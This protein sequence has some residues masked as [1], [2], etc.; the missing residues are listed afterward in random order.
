MYTSMGLMG[1]LANNRC[2]YM[3]SWFFTAIQRK[4]VVTRNAR[5]TVANMRAP[6]PSSETSAPA[7]DVRELLIVVSAL[8]TL[9]LVV[10][11]L[12]SLCR[13]GNRASTANKLLNRRTTI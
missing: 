13:R 1:L 9:L 3:A 6:A 5:V 7:L 2:H 11:Q 4:R 10:S 12:A 8:A